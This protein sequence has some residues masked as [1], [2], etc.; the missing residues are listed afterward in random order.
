MKKINTMFQDKRYEK[1]LKELFEYYDKDL[2]IKSIE[3]IKYNEEDILL[4]T[5]QELEKDIWSIG[6]V[7]DEFK[8]QNTRLIY[9][10]VIKE[11]KEESRRMKKAKIVCFA[12][13][14]NNFENSNLL[15]N[16][17]RH[18]GKESKVLVVNLSN[19][20]YSQ[21]KD[22]EISID[23]LL[24]LEDTEQ[25][26]VVNN[27]ESY[28]YLTTSKI[29]LEIS[30]FENYSKII[31]ILKNS[32]YSHIFINICLYIDQKNIDILNSSD[33]IIYYYSYNQESKTDERNFLTNIVSPK[34]KQVKIYQ[35]KNSYRVLKSNQD[36]VNINKVQDL[37]KLV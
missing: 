4:L 10:L 9:N 31:N 28:D 27:A 20:A 32:K 16:L 13:V 18:L 22:R 24:F 14:Y 15:N 7:K 12:N 30:K 26:F 33:S 5:D 25:E 17:A 29:P 6:F 2:E 19:L 37:I 36:N 21:S 35:D 1:K 8:Y 34:I 3:N 23:T 11:L